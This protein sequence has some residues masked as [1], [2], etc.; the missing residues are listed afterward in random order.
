ME[1]SGTRVWNLSTIR[2]WN[3]SARKDRIYLQQ[4]DGIYSHQEDGKYRQQVFPTVDVGEGVLDD[5]AVLYVDPADL[6]KLAVI[7]AVTVDNDTDMV[8]HCRCSYYY[9][10]MYIL[11]NTIQFCVVQVWTIFKYAVMYVI[12]VRTVCCFIVECS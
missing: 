9:R 6:R 2:G 11:C 3:L 7:S 12:G 5:L 1:L 4:E 8:T 10:T